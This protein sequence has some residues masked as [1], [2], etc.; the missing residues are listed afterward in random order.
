MEEQAAEV[1][2]E[3]RG[4]EAELHGEVHEL[5][6][7]IEVL[8]KKD[9]DLPVGSPERTE[10]IHLLE[11]SVATLAKELERTESKHDADIATSLS[12]MS[13]NSQEKLG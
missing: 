1:L 10:K 9:A 11:T 6:R 2:V 3:Q 12:H 5:L 8:K 13:K 4:R 7:T